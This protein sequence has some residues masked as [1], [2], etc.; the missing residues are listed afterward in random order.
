MKKF[1]IQYVSRY[2]EEKNYYTE[3]ISAKT[4]A[5]ALKKF[6]KLLGCDDYKKLLDP[7][8]HWED[9]SFISRFK[10]IN[11]VKETVCLHC[12]GTGK[13]YLSE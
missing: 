13:K 6:A 4:E 7:M 3:I 2:Y 1:E 8:F 10:C 9:G 5:N 11:V 12:N